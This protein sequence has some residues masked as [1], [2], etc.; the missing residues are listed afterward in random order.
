MNWP[1]EELCPCSPYLAAKLVNVTEHDDSAELSSD[2]ESPKKRTK[3]EDI[4]RHSA[5]AA[6]KCIF[7]TQMYKRVK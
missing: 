3:G 2:F 6:K 1:G 7:K 4:K 5:G